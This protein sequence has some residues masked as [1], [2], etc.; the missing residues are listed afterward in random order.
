MTSFTSTFSLNIF[1]WFSSLLRSI[2]ATRDDLIFLLVLQNFL[3]FLCLLAWLAI[4]LRP[5]RTRASE[6]AFLDPAAHPRAD[7]IVI[8]VTKVVTTKTEEAGAKQTDVS[9]LDRA[10][11]AVEERHRRASCD[12]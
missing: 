8:F 9:R 4:R 12:V 6:S 7:P 5:T 2:P 3:L 10:F 11:G 1:A